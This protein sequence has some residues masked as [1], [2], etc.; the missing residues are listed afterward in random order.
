[1]GEAPGLAA[2][3]LAFLGKGLLERNAGILGCSHQLD[4]CDLQQPAV[5]RVGDGLLL[6]RA[7]HDD[8]TELLRLDELELDGHID[9]LGQQLFYTVLAQQFAK[10]HQRGG[11]TRRAVFKVRLTCEELPCWR[12]APALN[13]TL[14]RLVEGVLQIQQ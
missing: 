3:L 9:G 5:R 7:V 12:L 14:V 11:V 4:P 8:S 13:H 10:L 6:H 2:Q 1:M